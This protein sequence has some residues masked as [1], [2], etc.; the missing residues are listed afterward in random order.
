MFRKSKV[1]N[2]YLYGTEVDN[3]F[4]SEYLSEAKGEYVKAYLLGLMYAQLG[5]QLDS[6]SLC[7]QLHMNK[8]ELEDCWAYWEERHVIKR[9]ADKYDESGRYTVEFVN[10][11]ELAFGGGAEETRKESVLDD[12]ELAQLF[13]KVQVATGRLINEDEMKGIIS[14]IEDYEIS[15]DLILYCYTYCAAKSKG[16]FN[17][18][19]K[20][21]KDWKQ[22]G[23]ETP[24]Q[25]ESY[26][27]GVDKRYS[28]YREIF[29]ELGINRNPSAE[30]KRMMSA[31]LAKG[32][33]MNDILAACKKTVGMT[34]PL[35]YLDKVMTAD[36]SPE[37]KQEDAGVKVSRI[38]EEIRKKNSEESAKR[39]DEIFGKF[40][41]LLETE[42][43]IKKE[44]GE[45]MLAMS[46]R[47]MKAI[48]ASKKRVASMRDEIKTTLL[49]AGY[50]ANALDMSY[51]CSK[52]KDTGYT[53][54]G[55][56]CSCYAEKLEMI[57][58]KR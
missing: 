39:R 56:V 25:A 23:I 40:P 32:I 10:L 30:E 53:E 14:L 28:D 54:D 12:K 3:L 38:Y 13:K 7:L 55:L 49:S 19:A 31:W 15:P 9:V 16:A 24:E 41:R 21:V 17:Y 34:N 11:R 45:Q 1:D 51:S 47:D 27:E 26:L 44:I 8:E 4:I 52:C 37:S 42:N 57:N 20:V 29:R 48:E 2:F 58:G 43:N 35:K 22:R 5:L 36:A 33:S 50:S 18:V 46:R 6:D